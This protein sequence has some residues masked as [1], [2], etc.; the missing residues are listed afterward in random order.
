MNRVRR[1]A[2]AVIA[3]TLTVLMAAGPLPSS[4]ALAQEARSTPP[5]GQAWDPV[6]FA[7]PDEVAEMVDLLMQAPG[8]LTGEIIGFNG[9]WF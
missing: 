8:Y 5:S 9:G 3:V 6:V 2:R 1:R 4:L 7:S